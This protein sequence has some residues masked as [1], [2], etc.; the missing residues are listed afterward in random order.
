MSLY[1]SLKSAKTEEDV[2]DAYVPAL[3]LKKYSKNMVD[4][5]TDEIWFEAKEAG[6]SPVAMFA[7]L[8]IYV[9]NAKKEGRTPS[10]I[11]SGDRSAKSGVDGNQTFTAAFN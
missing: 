9:Q 6:T 2:K 4:I 10:T 3:G 1:D 7:Q 5:Q 8:L 11:F